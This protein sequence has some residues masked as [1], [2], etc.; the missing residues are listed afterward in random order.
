[1]STIDVRE[2]ERRRSDEPRRCRDQV[3]GWVLRERRSRWLRGGRGRSRGEQ[4][5]GGT[6]PIII[7]SF[8]SP[9]VADLTS[10]TKLDVQ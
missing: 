6:I 9:P 7:Q 8:V 2:M 4:P 1:M 5:Q 3:A 10:V